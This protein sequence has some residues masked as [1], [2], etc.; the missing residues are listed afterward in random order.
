MEYGKVI[1]YVIVY[2]MRGI[3]FYQKFSSKRI[4]YDIVKRNGKQKRNNE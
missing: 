4:L 2:L 1:S 3:R